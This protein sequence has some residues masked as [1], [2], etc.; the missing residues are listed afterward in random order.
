MARGGLFGPGQRESIQRDE[1]TDPLTVVWQG[2]WALIMFVLAYCIGRGYVAAW[3]WLTYHGLHSWFGAPAA[4]GI[5]AC[6]LVGG[7][8]VIE[9]V[10]P[11]WPNPRNATDSTRPLTPLS[12]ERMAPKGGSTRI[13]LTDLLGA[14][15]LELESEPDDE[16]E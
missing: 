11:N 7:M 15:D 5:L 4:I 1:R 13:K 6:L 16:L 8:L 12:K 2:L 3:D 10:D 14:L 9:V